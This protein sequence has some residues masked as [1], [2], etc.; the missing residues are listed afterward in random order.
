MNEVNYDVIDLSLWQHSVQDVP[1]DTDS[2][3]SEGYFGAKVTTDANSG[4][5]IQ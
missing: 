1:T 2:G 4:A 3:A 5:S